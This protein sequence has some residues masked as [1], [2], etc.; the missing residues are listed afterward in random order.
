MIFG[1][2]VTTIRNW[3]IGGL[4]TKILAKLVTTLPEEPFMKWGYNFISLIK[5]A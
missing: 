1:E 4:K 5:P 2:G 3:R